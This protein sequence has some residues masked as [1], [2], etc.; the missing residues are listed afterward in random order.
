MAS[1]LDPDSFGDPQNS[2]HAPAG[3]DIESLGP[4]D[5][6]DTGSDVAGPGLIDDDALIAVGEESNLGGNDI[7]TDRIGH[8]R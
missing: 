5:S 3:H 4:S 6:S 7:D 1:T 8:C 2:P